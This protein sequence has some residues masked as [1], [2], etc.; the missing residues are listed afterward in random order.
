[1]KRVV[2]EAPGRLLIEQVPDPVPGDG[3]VVIR[4][5]AA[6]TCGTDLKAYRRGH[7]KMPMPTPFG[8]E[9]AGEIVAV[10]SQ[11]EQFREG[12]LLMA[13]NTGPCGSCFFCVRDQENLCETIMDEMVLGAYAEYLLVPE[14]VLRRNAFVKPDTL[15][16]SSAALLEPLS[17]VCFGLAHA[18][19]SCLEDDAVS[20]I[21][22]AGPIAMLWLR[23]LKARG[24]GRVVIAGR[25]QPRLAAA[26]QLGADEVVGEDGD[27]GTVVN[28]LTAG[29]GADL[30]VECTGLPEVWSVAPSYARKG[31]TV[32]L[33]GG[34]AAGTKAEIDTYRVHYDGV[35]IISPFHFRPR[36][37]AESHRLLTMPGSDW[38]GLISKSVTLADVPEVFAG[39]GDSG[40]I[41]V[42]VLPHG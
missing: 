8:H 10:G 2:L 41:K 32:V 3:D 25:R 34:C 11:V 13:A 33:F 1:M 9:F 37:V 14:R 17:A 28:A 30:V 19:A 36:D 7:P 22:G 29:R 12:Q 40:A 42:A 31:G 4:V 39:L 24:R 15:E 6:L 21:I 38:S 5:R 23:A 16:W 26:L 18:P 35:R 20:V 27:V